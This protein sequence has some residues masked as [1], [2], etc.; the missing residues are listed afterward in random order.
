MSVEERRKGRQ[1]A[2]ERAVLVVSSHSY[3]TGRFEKGEGEGRR[4]ACTK[5][6]LLH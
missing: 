6:R 4:T 5:E 1:R 3:S 2:E